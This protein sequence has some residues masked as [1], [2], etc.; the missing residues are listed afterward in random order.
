VARSAPTPRRRARRAADATAPGGPAADADLSVE[1]FRR[2]GKHAIDLL[3]DYYESVPDRPIL[4][5][6]DDRRLRATFGAP[7]PRRGADPARVLDRWRDVVVPNVA[8]L[9]SPRFFGYVH[10]SGLRLAVLADLLS[11][12]SNPNVA[13]RRISP[14]E[15]EIEATVVGWLARMIGYPARSGGLLLG[16]GMAANYT[17]MQAALRRHAGYD[18][19]ADGLQRPRGGPRFTLYMSEEGHVTIPRASDLLNL[20]RNAVKVVPCR[21]DFAM[22]VGA[23]REMIDADVRNGD[24]PFLVV[25]QAGSINVGAVDPFR[26]IAAVCRERGLWFHVD[27]AAGGFGAMLPELRAKYAGLA[28]AD[29]VTVDPHKWLYLPKECGGLL[30]RD[31]NTLHRAFRLEADYLEA[32]AGRGD[33]ARNYRSLGPESSRGFRALKVWMALQHLGTE[34]YVRLFRQNLACVGRLDRRVRADPEFEALHV[35]T[36][37]IYSFRYVPADLSGTAGGDRRP[38]TQTY[39]DRL[40]AAIVDR[41]NRSGDVFLTTTRLRG[42]TALRV[43]ICNHRTTFADVDRLFRSLK[44][45]GR[46]VDRALRGSASRHRL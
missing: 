30:V 13:D 29:S 23:L 34:G 5:R 28:R 11:V 36:L 3:A 27:G 22:D 20:G 40:N 45:A 2:L 33:G 46:A 8:H 4:P 42:V 31:P 12:G 21:P 41:V 35:P 6:I 39:L 24:R 37:Y 32:Q 9:T 38:S 18:S 17:A 19:A 1:E 7:L 43:S 16:G 25:G 10:G 44:D 14:G 26:A 15:S